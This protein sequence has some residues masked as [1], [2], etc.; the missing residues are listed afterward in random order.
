MTTA[1]QTTAP[2]GS[3][4]RRAASRIVP[5]SG[6]RA[7]DRV[8]ERR[9]LQR[10]RPLN[11]E[12]VGRYGLEVRHGPFTG[13]RY[14]P[15]Q[16]QI[17]GHLIPKLVGSY[18]SQLYPWLEREWIGGEL[19]TFVDVGCAEG[20]YAVGLARTMP[21]VT[22]YA[23]DT[24]GPA[25]EQCEELARINGVEQRVLVG[26]EC[27]PR[28][29]ATLPTSRVALLSDCEG[30]ER[31]L[32][33]PDLAPNLRGWSIIVEQHDNVDPS[34]SAT[35]R[36][37]FRDSHEIETVGSSAAEGAGIEEL[38]WMTPGQRSFALDERPLPMTWALLR[39]R[40]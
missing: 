39:P 40:G 6:K 36:E 11:E 26:A 8:R 22:V 30:Y 1:A 13:M 29:L 34:I 18:E 15:G 33:D 28:T 37:R 21:N 5:D 14:L 20:Y 27:S 12:F 7:I 24:Y 31:T 10:M 4:L 9:Y 35:I 17:S 2:A 32:L 25:R 19:D 16:E 38:A 23:Y 3:V